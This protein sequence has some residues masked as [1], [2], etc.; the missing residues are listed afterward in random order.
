MPAAEREPGWCPATL[1]SLDRVG[2]DGTIDG[3]IRLLGPYRPFDFPH[4]SGVD[5]FTPIRLRGGE[6]WLTHVPYP[7]MSLTAL[8]W[9]DARGASWLLEGQDADEATLRSVA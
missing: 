4:Y 6:A 5:R 8:S 1:L 3:A 7:T 9:T 2:G